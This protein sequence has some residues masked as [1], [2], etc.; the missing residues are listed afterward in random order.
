MGQG[1]ELK[2]V[3]GAV[4][5]KGVYTANLNAAWL[6]RGFCSEAKMLICAVLQT[7]SVRHVLDAQV[8]FNAAHVVPLFQATATRFTDICFQRS[9]AA[10]P[11]PVTLKQLVDET[12]E[13]RD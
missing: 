6:S 4:H 3:N 12:A 11:R 1:N 10:I 13:S 8:V 2:V 9:S 5:G 7:P